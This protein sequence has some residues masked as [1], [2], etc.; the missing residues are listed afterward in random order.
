MTTTYDSV[1]NAEDFKDAIFD[2]K[3]IDTP[4]MNIAKKAKATGK[5][6]EWQQRDLTAAGDNA[7]VEG[8]DNPTKTYTPTVLRSNRVQ[9]MDKAFK[10]SD[11]LEEIKKHGRKSELRD[12][13]AVKLRELKN[14]GEHAMTGMP[15][16][17]AVAGDGSSTAAR[18]AGLAGQVH[19]D[20]RVDH[21]GD[22]GTTATKFT[23]ANGEASIKKGQLAAY[24]SGGNPDTLLINP[25]HADAIAGFA[26]QTGRNR[27]IEDKRLVDCIDII[28]TPHGSL[29]VVKGRFMDST[30][31]LGID[32]EYADV[33]VLQ[34]AKLKTLAVTG[35]SQ[36]MMWKWE[37]CGD[38]LNNKTWFVIDHI[39]PA[40]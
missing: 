3:T 26:Q 29:S 28:D 35:H 4:Y 31:I 30:T 36:P 1:G 27:D 38:V 32:S 23:A 20:N 5:L 39:D 9:L 2:T 34:P 40:A 33:A 25:E 14:D 15:T 24:N 11:T 12:Q 7:V 19:A 8:D 18:M 37:G 13:S 21:S 16:Q 6:H 17:A 10:I 22:G